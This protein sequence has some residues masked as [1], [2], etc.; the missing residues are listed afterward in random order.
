MTPPDPVIQNPFPQRAMWV[1][2][3]LWSAL[4][5]AGVALLA[6]TLLRSACIGI[7]LGGAYQFSLFWNAR[8]P[9]AVQGQLTFSAL[10]VI[11]FALMIA[12]ASHS[13]GV[14]LAIV[15]FGFLS[16]KGGVAA[17]GAVQLWKARRLKASRPAG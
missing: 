5:L 11:T 17:I 14:N 12:A 7:V 1:G 13:I 15:I 8:H 16:Y 9:R 4:L 10:R 2:W 3:A 6:P